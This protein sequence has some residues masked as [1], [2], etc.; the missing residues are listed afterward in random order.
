MDLAALSAADVADQFRL[1]IGQKQAIVKAIG[2][3]HA[4]MAAAMV[5]AIDKDATHAGFAHFA[6]GDVLRHGVGVQMMS[7]RDLFQ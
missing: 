5:A 1:D 6:E 3:H 2:I 4:V 7:R